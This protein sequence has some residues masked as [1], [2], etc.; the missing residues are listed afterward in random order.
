MPSF[1][2]NKDKNRRPYLYGDLS[3]MPYARVWRGVFFLWKNWIWDWWRTG[4]VRGKNLRLFLLSN[5]KKTK[6]LPTPPILT[7]SIQI[8]TNYETHIFKKWG[9]TYPQTPVA[10]PVEQSRSFCCKDHNSKTSAEWYSN[11]CW[12]RAVNYASSSR[13]GM[14]TVPRSVDYTSARLF[15]LQ[16]TTIIWREEACHGVRALSSMHALWL[17]DLERLWWCSYLISCFE[18]LGTQGEDKL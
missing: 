5:H 9:G 17:T 14:Q 1:L 2:P 18:Q 7:I 8:W 6:F 11:L 15:C 10:S 12:S 4:A 16:I 13:C 3:R